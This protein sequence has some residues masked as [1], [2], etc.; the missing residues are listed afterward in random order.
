MDNSRVTRKVRVSYA[1]SDDSDSH[2]SKDLTSVNDIYGD[3][4]FEDED[5]DDEDLDDSELRSGRGAMRFTDEADDDEDEASGSATTQTQDRSTRGYSLRTKPSVSLKGTESARTRV[6]VKPKA[7]RVKS[8][9]KRGSYRKKASRQ[10]SAKNK[11]MRRYLRRKTYANVFQMRPSS[12][13]V[14]L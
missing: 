3:D 6:V 1:E 12:P 7:N 4:G 9:S 5:D 8:K 2:T 11:S 13:S 10:A 14:T